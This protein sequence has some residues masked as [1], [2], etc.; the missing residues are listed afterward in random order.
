MDL[1]KLSD[2]ML[3]VNYSLAMLGSD[4]VK[5][6]RIALKAELM[7]R[8]TPELTGDIVPLLDK[9]IE[10]VRKWCDPDMAEKAGCFIDPEFYVPELRQAAASMY[11]E[12]KQVADHVDCQPNALAIIAT[13]ETER[14]RIRDKVKEWRD[15]ALCNQKKHVQHT[16]AEERLDA[17]GVAYQFVL[18]LIDGEL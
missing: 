13:I 9:Y 10:A 5:S 14:K 12:L 15:G 18:D 11:G 1:K 16:Q 8:L 6:E 7:R 4:E 2:E 17:M 3:V